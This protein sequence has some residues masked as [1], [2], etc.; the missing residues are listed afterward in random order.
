MTPEQEAAETAIRLRA[1][2]YGEQLQELVNTLGVEKI[3]SAAAFM[4]L[5][6]EHRLNFTDISKVTG[7][8]VTATAALVWGWHDKG[9][10]L[11]AR[12]V[13]GSQQDQR[14]VFVELL[15]ATRMK[16]KKF[17]ACENELDHT[18]MEE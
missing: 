16:I 11:A 3:T 17:L 7:T 15:P 2:R 14:S 5:Y 8:S 13:R 6:C 18:V 12:P 9:L 4:A 10:V 1:A